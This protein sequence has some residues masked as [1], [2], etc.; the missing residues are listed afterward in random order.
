MVVS[1]PRILAASRRWTAI[2]FAAACFTW[3]S[4]VSADAG[5]DKALARSLFDD[6]RRLA[7]DG[8]YSEAC[9]KFQESQ[10]L[11]PGMGTQ[12]NL[13]DCLEHTG[14]TAT[15]WT[16]FLEVAAEAKEKEQPDREKVARDR[17]SA[18][19][20]KLARITVVV[21]KTA[22]ARDLQVLIDNTRLG[23]AAWGV[24]TPIDPGKHTIRATAPGYRS[25]LTKVEVL[26]PGQNVT[27]TV[28]RMDLEPPAEA[29]AEK[30]VAPIPVEAKSNGRKT[31][32]LIIGGVG[33]AS[34]L[35]AGGFA[36]NTRS[37]L[38]DAEAYCSDLDCWDQRGV[39]LHHQAVT[40]QTIALVATGVGVAGLGVGAWLYF[41]AR[42]QGNAS[43]SVGLI[44]SGNGMALKGRW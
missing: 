26:G 12:F 3:G 20:P 8:K 29:S 35:V 17:A 9:P 6:A 33:V 30:P 21:P 37:K 38:N 2:A 16:M 18:L 23:R 39:D 31:A 1:S 24:A 4:Q 34:L 19:E 22:Q 28:P 7:S 13:A 36:I 44:P 32:G 27:T 41:G 42:G 5:H 25:W 43:A 11:D 40:S 15:A 14:R 10:R